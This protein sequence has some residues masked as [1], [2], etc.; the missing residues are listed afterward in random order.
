LTDS[1]EFL[2]LNYPSFL[3]TIIQGIFSWEIRKRDRQSEKEAT[4]ARQDNYYFFNFKIEQ[5]FQEAL[6]LRKIAGNVLI[7]TETSLKIIKKY[8]ISFGKSSCEWHIPIM[9]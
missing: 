6:Y 9:Q 2:G 5:P 3:Q 8:K 4:I 1:G 7:K